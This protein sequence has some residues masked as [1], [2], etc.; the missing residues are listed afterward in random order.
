MRNFFATLKQEILFEI[1]MFFVYSISA[2]ILALI[3]SLMAFFIFWFQKGSA[4]NDNLIE[5]LLLSIKYPFV[6]HEAKL[7]L[8]SWHIIFF[9]SIMGVIHLPI[10][11]KYTE[12]ESGNKIFLPSEKRTWKQWIVRFFVLLISN[13][14]VVVLAGIIMLSIDYLISLA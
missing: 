10:F 2:F 5:I 14:I 11:M 3:T 4:I 9:F 1:K 12:D 8:Y 7:L 13:S 6:I